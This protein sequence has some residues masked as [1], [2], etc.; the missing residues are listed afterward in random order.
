MITAAQIFFGVAYAQA[1]TLDGAKGPAPE[2]SAGD[3]LIPNLLLVVAIIGLFVLMVYL[4]QKRRNREHNEMLNELR[5]GDKIVTTG[6][7]VGKIAK[8]PGDTEIILETG[9]GNRITVLR[10]AIT[11][12]YDDVVGVG[13]KT[14]N[15]NNKD[16]DKKADDKK[17]GDKSLDAS[18]SGGKSKDSK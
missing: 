14:A 3:V 7:M 16:D 13:G 1:P 12:K 15:E 9:E 11:G 18:E 17:A 8:A 6:G 2:V 10:A 5:K 4:P